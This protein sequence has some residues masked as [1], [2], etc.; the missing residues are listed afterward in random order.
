MWR[1]C[2]SSI[3]GSIAVVDMSVPP[4][5]RF[6]RGC[7]RSAPES[8]RPVLSSCRMETVIRASGR[9]GQAEEWAL[10]LA[11]AGIPHR[12]EPWGDRFMLIVRDDDVERA[13]GALED[14]EGEEARPIPT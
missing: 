12:V 1:F 4:W 2:S 11:A 5:Q 13:S 3:R 6:S 7:A 14:F 8:R 9:A 10:V